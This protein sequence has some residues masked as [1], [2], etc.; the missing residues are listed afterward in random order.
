MEQPKLFIT[1]VK[2]YQG[3]RE[4]HFNLDLDGAVGCKFSIEDASRG[5]SLP[6]S[7]DGGKTWLH[8]STA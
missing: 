4:V 7:T 1:D 3:G 2:S 5:G 8:K 6:V